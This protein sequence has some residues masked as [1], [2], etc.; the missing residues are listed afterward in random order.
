[1]AR[2]WPALSLVAALALVIAGDAAAANVTS[3]APQTLVSALQDAGYKAKLT[4]DDAGDPRI[5]TA[6]DGNDIT[7]ALLDCVNN[8]GCHTV[9]FMGVWNCGDTVDG[10]RKAAA[11]ATAEESP[12]KVLWSEE[13][14][15]AVVFMYML[16]DKA[17]VSPELF[18]TNLEQFSFYNR[19]F[20]E[21]ANAK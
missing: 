1:M 2:I 20:V 3:F 16:F 7:V 13:R 18:I 15:T 21:H 11:E 4:K 6:V 19:R 14:K 9:E 8:A 10:C 17:G 5:E 12:S